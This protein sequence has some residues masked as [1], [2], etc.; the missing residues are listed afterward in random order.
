[1]TYFNAE[2][3]H[4]GLGQLIPAHHAAGSADAHKEGRVERSA[5]L[6]RLHHAYRRAA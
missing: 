4:Q 1:V 3:P 6:G 2:R 5:I